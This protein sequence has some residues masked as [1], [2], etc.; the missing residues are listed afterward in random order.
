MIALL[1]KFMI[2]VMEPADPVMRN[3]FV[4]LEISRQNALLVKLLEMLLRKDI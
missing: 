3:A 1:T 2:M 4:A